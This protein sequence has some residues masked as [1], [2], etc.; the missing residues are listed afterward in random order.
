M[1]IQYYTLLPLTTAGCS[2]RG[3]P[4]FSGTPFRL[5]S[6]P[7]LLSDNPF[8]RKLA[9]ASLGF[10]KLFEYPPKLA[11]PHL[12]R[13][14]SD[15]RIRRNRTEAA[16]AHQHAYRFLVTRSIPGRNIM[17]ETVILTISVKYE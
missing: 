14:G 3:F 17:D 1:Q 4:L 16:D 9:F 6:P 8:A 15:E 11:F 5:Q 10:I 13:D 2:S 7:R 12:E